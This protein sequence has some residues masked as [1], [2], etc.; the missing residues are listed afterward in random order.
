MQR[1]Q[2]QRRRRMQTPLPPWTSFFLDG[3]ERDEEAPQGTIAD[4]LELFE[5]RMTICAKPENSP[6]SVLQYLQEEGF[7]FGRLFEVR[8]PR[9]RI[10][11]LHVMP[12]LGGLLHKPAN[13]E[14]FVVV[15]CLDG[16]PVGL[17]EGL[18]NGRHSFGHQFSLA[19]SL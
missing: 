18:R 17:E 12:F 14:V 13:E 4:L 1:G 2:P 15:D 19:I 5:L 11:L 9:S 6:F 3:R 8:V 7:D 16:S 10:F